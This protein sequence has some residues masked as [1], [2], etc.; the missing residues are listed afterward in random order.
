M[1][2][3]SLPPFKKWSFIAFISSPFYSS[4][5]TLLYL[6]H[7]P[8]FILG[9]LPLSLFLFSP[10]ST[11]VSSS[12]YQGAVTDSV[13]LHNV[14]QMQDTL[15]ELMNRLTNDRRIPQISQMQLLSRIRLAKHFSSP[16]HRRKCIMAR[17][18]AISILGVKAI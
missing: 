11:Q 14:D 2:P 7:L 1:L 12:P 15:P 17:L 8:P 9:F 6:L 4:F 3:F 5:H 10:S 16:A 13:L 18:Q